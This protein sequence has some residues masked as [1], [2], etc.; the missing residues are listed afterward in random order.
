MWLDAGPRAAAEGGE[1]VSD[2]H[3]HGP[4]WEACALCGFDKSLG[5]HG[6]FQFRPESMSFI[7]CKPI[8]VTQN[9]RRLGVVTGITE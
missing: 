4:M 7:I 8:V 9:P 5:E 2:E 3:T 1:T 6:V